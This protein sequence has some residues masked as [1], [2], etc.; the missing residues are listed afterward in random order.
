MQTRNGMQLSYVLD[1]KYTFKGGI[2]ANLKKSAN[3]YPMRNFQNLPHLQEHHFAEKKA[4][5]YFARA[6]NKFKYYT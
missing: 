5:V 6:Q 3:S 1:N 4:R 2:I